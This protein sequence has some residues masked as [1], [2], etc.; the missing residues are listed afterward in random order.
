M[1]LF[2]LDGH[3]ALVTGASKGIGAGLARGLAEAGA[4]LIL[5]ALSLI[6]I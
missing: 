3:C 4:D 2:E 1:R 6:H 5:L